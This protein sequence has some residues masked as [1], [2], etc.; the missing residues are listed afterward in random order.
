MEVNSLA[1]EKFR[2]KREA[3]HPCV[4][5]SKAIET[6]GAW[7]ALRGI[8]DMEELAEAIRSAFV[9]IGISLP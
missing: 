1:V 8:H 5:D 2:V 6:R 3:M 4:S 9:S 7:R